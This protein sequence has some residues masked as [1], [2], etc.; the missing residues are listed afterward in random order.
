M[1]SESVMA[2]LFH[3]VSEKFMLGVHS[4]IKVQFAYLKIHPFKVKTI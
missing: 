1:D 4:I 3:F 2:I